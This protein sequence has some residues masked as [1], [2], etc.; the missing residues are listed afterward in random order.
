M[1]ELILNTDTQLVTVTGDSDPTVSVLWDRAVQQAV[2]ETAVGP[3]IASRAYSMVHTA[4][5]DAWAS[6]DPVAVPTQLEDSL[7]R[8]EAEI[9]EAN[10]AEAMS[11]AAYRVL[12]DLFPEQS[13]IFEQLM[14]DLGHDINNDTIDPTVAAGIGN[15]AAA[16]LLEFRHQDN[17]NQLGD[18]PAGILGVAYSDTTGY[19]P[20]NPN[21]ENINDISLWTPEYVPVDNPDGTLQQFLTPQWGDVVPFALD[22]GAELRPIEPEPF[23]L[24]AGEVDFAEQTI[25]L[26]D[27]LEVAISRDLIGTVI[28]PEFVTQAEEIV[29]ISANLTDEQKL[30]A[31]FWE[32]GGGTSFPPGTW[33]TFGQFVSDRDGHSTDDDAKLFFALGNAVFDAGVATWE[34]KTFYDYARPVRAIRELGRLGLIGQFNE[35]LDGF[36]IEAWQ[37]GAGTQTILATD[38]LTYQIPGGNVSP[39]F[40]EYTSGHSAFSAAG[41][42]ILRLFSGSDDFGGSVTFEAGQSLFEPDITP[43]ETTTLEW[44]TF[45]EASDEAGL[46]RIYGGIHFDDGDTNGRT[47]GR[48]IGSAVFAEAQSYINGEVTAQFELD[49][50][51]YRFRNQIQE[52]GYI[53]VG[54]AERGAIL[55]DRSDELVLEGVAFN[56]ATSEDAGLIAMYRFQSEVNP[57]AYLLVGEA[58]RAAILSDSDFSAAYIEEGI[59]FYVPEADSDTG[60]N[61]YRFRSTTLAGGYIYVDETERQDIL[62]DFSNSF[63]EE[64]LAFAAVV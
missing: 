45:S 2:I 59:A 33:M 23:L 12:V 26:E 49:Q 22:S 4:I 50:P 8:P 46:S 3:T 9:T 30:I 17:S 31:E 56:V 10:K 44:E 20:I 51:I 35:D 24:V 43:Q 41:A 61:I 27:G 64:G 36:A 42:E 6:Y 40:A 38:F 58:E 5:Y 14:A 28:N 39:P 54:D 1:T 53:F 32:D 34:A 25:I 62:D 7:Q 16:S 63:I 48:E 19:Q 52:G 18:D 60:A 21:P 57:G 37:P 29:Q 47:L 13:A 15:L 55:S 11:F